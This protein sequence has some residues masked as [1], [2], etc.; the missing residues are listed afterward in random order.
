MQASLAKFSLW[1]STPDTVCS[2]RLATL[3]S[4]VIA[5]RVHRA[6][7]SRL[8]RAYERL[9]AEVRAPRARYEAGSVLLGRERPFGQVGLL[10]QIFGLTEEDEGEVNGDEVDGRKEGGEGDGSEEDDDEE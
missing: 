10:L 1:L 5:A 7:S 8:V 3:S 9:C 2:P 6:A 4:A